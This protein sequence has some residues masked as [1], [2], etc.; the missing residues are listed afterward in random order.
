LAALIFPNLDLAPN[1][2]KEIVLF[3]SELKASGAEYIKLASFKL[4]V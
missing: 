3:E 4:K 1:P 2:V